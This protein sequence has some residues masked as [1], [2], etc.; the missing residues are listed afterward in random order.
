MYTLCSSPGDGLGSWKSPSSNVRP[1]L[2]PS[3]QDPARSCHQSHSAASVTYLHI[4]GPLS[5]LKPK[6]EKGLREL[7]QQLWDLEGGF[8]CSRAAHKLNNLFPSSGLDW[9]GV[10]Q[11]CWVLPK[12]YVASSYIGKMEHRSKEQAALVP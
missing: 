10:Q 7:S 9:T 11:L 12:W 3:V 4:A 6:R 5:T 2:I 8:P 1:R